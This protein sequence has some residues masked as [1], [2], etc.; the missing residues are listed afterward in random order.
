MVDFRL[1]SQK[2]V[3]FP[4]FQ[5]HFPEGLFQ[6]ILFNISVH[7][8]RRWQKFSAQSSFLMLYRMINKI[9]ENS[10]I[11]L[12]RSKVWNPPVVIMI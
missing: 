8:M 9:V 1:Y 3:K 2:K 10:E 7:A 12:F 11:V 6:T 4:N 5:E